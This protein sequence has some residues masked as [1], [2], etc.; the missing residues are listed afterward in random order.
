LPFGPPE[1]SGRSVSAIKG[2]RK[3]TSDAEKCFGFWAKLSSDCAICMRVCPFNRD[4]DKWPHRLWLKLALSPL[5]KLALWL[6]RK[7][8]K[9]SKPS[10]WWRKAG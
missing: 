4:F 5:R 1:I 8:G 2:V 9:R 3:W 7:R 10:E 6:D